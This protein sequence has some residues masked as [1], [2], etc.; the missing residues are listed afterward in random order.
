MEY[1]SLADVFEQVRLTKV[2]GR[3]KQAGKVCSCGRLEPLGDP[4]MGNRSHSLATIV[5]VDHGG[6]GQEKFHS[7]HRWL[8]VVAEVQ[9]VEK[10][11]HGIGVVIRN[12]NAD[13]AGGCERGAFLEPRT[14]HGFENGGSIADQGGGDSNADSAMAAVSGWNITREGIAQ[15]TRLPCPS[16]DRE[17]R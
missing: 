2:V 9:S 11:D 7:W 13:R 17:C 16:W 8:S 6:Q 10:N 15:L 1:Q 14:E 4:E 12:W 5:F 3:K